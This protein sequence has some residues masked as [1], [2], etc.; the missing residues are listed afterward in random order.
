MAFPLLSSVP[1]KPGQGNG[2]GFDFDVELG[3]TEEEIGDD[4]GKTI[5]DNR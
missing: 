1:R 4:P 2:L 5:Y 3:N